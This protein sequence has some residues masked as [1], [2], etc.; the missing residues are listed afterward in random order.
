[1]RLKLPSSAA[2]GQ[3]SK[4]T[5]FYDFVSPWCYIAAVAVSI[6]IKVA[7]KHIWHFNFFISNDWNQ[8]ERLVEQLKPV[9]VDVEWVP[10]SLPGL[11]Y[12]NKVPVVSFNYKIWVFAE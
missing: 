1:M 7:L 2:S 10:V 11:I 3:K 12:A 4:L 9:N 8:I 6:F 5:F